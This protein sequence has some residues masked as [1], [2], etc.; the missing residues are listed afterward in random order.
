MPDLRGDIQGSSPE[1]D[2]SADRLPK[3]L[4]KRSGPSSTSN[5]GDLQREWLLL[6]GLPEQEARE[7]VKEHEERNGRS[8]IK[9]PVPG[10]E[11]VALR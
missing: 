10:R 8:G 1:R 5:W 4:W 2:V 3:L 11:L 7:E 9:S 6:D